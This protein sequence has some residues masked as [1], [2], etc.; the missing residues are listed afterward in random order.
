[1]FA[2]CAEL[3]LIRGDPEKALSYA[4]ECLDIA[5]TTGRQKNIAKGR[6]LRGYAMVGMGRVA[7][8][9]NELVAA[10]D[11]ARRIGNPP[12]LW[13]A[14]SALGDAYRIDDREEDAVA[15]HVEALS[16]VQSVAEGLQD[17][18]RRKVFLESEEVRHIRQRALVAE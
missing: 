11:V 6:R 14:L 8:G 16:V 7:E 13:K 18:R 1:L 17:E 3:W 5:V 4:D 9:V 2:S 12:Q 10:R 15:A